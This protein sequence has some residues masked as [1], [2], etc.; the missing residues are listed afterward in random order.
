LGETVTIEE[1]E[2]Y[3]NRQGRIAW[4]GF[5]VETTEPLGLDLSIPFQV[6]TGGAATG[7]TNILRI[8]LH[9][10]KGNRIFIS[11]SQA[12]DL[13]HLAD[14]NSVVY[15]GSASEAEAFIDE[16]ATE[17]KRLNEK[18]EESKKKLK[19]FI[20]G[21]P[22][23]LVLIDDGDTFI[24]YVAAKGT[25]VEPLLKQ[26]GELGVCF[27]ATT[28][29]SQFRGLGSIDKPFKAPQTG[30]V[31][32]NPNDAT[33]HFPNVNVHRTYKASP[34]IGFWTRRGEVKKIKLP[35]LE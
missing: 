18:R 24:S 27:I 6:I 10:F 12:G 14:D 11:D 35:F 2:P 23:V 25:A 29:S 32:G 4:V 30:L 22:A 28:V 1:L 26:A 31:L 3:F 16:L 9:Q 34:G 13:S 17:V 33:M 21:E 15:M 7:K 8:L 5:D 20:A 19:D